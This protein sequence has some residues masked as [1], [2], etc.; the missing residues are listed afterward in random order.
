MLFN[1]IKG[2]NKQIF[3][4]DTERVIVKKFKYVIVGGGTAAYNAVKKI[5][6]NDT[7]EEI[8]VVSQE[9]TVPYKRPPLSKEIWSNED[10]NLLES[11]EYTD[12]SGKLSNVHYD[13][14][15]MYAK[16][17]NIHLIKNK[18]VVDINLEKKAI[19]L[20]HGIW[21]G[22]DKC[23][24]ATGVRPGNLDSYTAKNDNRITTYRYLDDFK[25]LYNFVNQGDK[26]ITIIGGS[27][28]ASELSCAI[29]LNVGKKKNIKITQV[30]PEDGVL[31]VFLPEYLSEYANSQMRNSGIQLRTKQI[32]TDICESPDSGKLLVKLN[33]GSESFETDYVIVDVVMVPNSNISKSKNLEID[34]TNGGIVV[35]A[36][37]QH[38]SDIY[39]AG[40]VASYYDTL[41]G[42]R[43]RL[44]QNDH[45][46]A[47]GELAG[48]NMSSNRNLPY[49]Y[50][51]S[52]SSELTP[53]FIF[54]GIGNTDAKLKTYSVWEDPNNQSLNTPNNKNKINI[55][56]LNSDN[57]V[58]GVVCFR[59]FGKMNIAR[60]II[61]QSKPIENLNELNDL[62]PFIQFK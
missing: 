60:D 21:Y 54:E 45:A 24:I 26:H 8:L 7:N 59:N 25:K 32:V 9:D 55:F 31:S 50:Q 34:S 13:P 15:S 12:W 49:T 6:E 4:E 20:C 10:P 58:V 56:Y 37:L 43:K 28:L 14:E 1:L 48:I 3:K 40:D 41:T 51:P 35:N 53:N 16:S 17:D 22:Y 47:T 46:R 11:L 38:R 57:I 2:R 30:V 19:Q 52:Y 18:K 29:N 42:Q 62:I 23:L 39:V 61:Y 33:E 5:I 27:F 44:E 36:E